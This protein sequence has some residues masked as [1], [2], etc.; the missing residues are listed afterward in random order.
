MLAVL[1]GGGLSD[2]AGCSGL[3][4]AGLLGWAGQGWAGSWQLALLGG[5]AGLA[6]VGRL[7]GSCRLDWAR[8][9]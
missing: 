6:G 2:W 8:M 9:S 5:W 3:V 4:L 7:A 1:G